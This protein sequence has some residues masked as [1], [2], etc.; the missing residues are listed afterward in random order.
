MFLAMA[1]MKQR[2]ITAA[3]VDIVVQNVASF[4]IDPA[5]LA[6]HNRRLVLVCSPA[7]HCKLQSR[8][9]AD[10]FDD[11]IVVEDFSADVLC[12]V[13]QGV[14]NKGGHASE[15]ARLLC[16]DEYSLYTVAVVRDKLGIPG[17][18]PPQ[19][20]SFTDKLAMKAALVGSGIRMPRHVS[21]EDAAFRDDPDGYV[22]AVVEQ[23]GLPAFVKPVSESGSVGVAKIDTAAQLRSWAQTADDRIDYEIDE[24]V[25]GTLYHVDSAVYEGQIVHFRVNRNVH[26]CHEYAA[27]RINSSVTVPDDDPVCA[28]LLRFNEDVLTALTDKPRSGVFHHE[29]FLNPAGEAVFLE[30]AARAPAALI[31]ATGQ[32]RWGIDIEEALF[33]LQRDEQVPLVTSRGPF[34]AYVYF[35]KFAGRVVSLRQPEIHSPHQWNWNIAVGDTLGDATD[36]RDFAASVLLWNDDYTALCSDLENLDTTIPFDVKT[37]A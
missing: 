26:P 19:L 28:S 15:Q 12:E 2:T 5:V 36:I 10:V 11:V 1:D 4:R 14:L 23:V 3:R 37:S 31:P 9:R 16:H 30:I 27:G 6:R 25:Q 24:Y 29:I 17:D 13:V 18:R 21:W 7:N 8:N 34:A 20:R 32:I 22:D 33:K 35:P